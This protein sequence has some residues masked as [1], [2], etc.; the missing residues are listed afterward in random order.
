MDMFGGVRPGEAKGD[1]PAKNTGQH[2]Y[3][4]HL[5]DLLVSRLVVHLVGR[6]VCR[7]ESCL[8]GLW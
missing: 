8:V 1:M 3:A 7:L 2:S 6:L 4:G 5:V